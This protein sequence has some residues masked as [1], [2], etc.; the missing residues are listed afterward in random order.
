MRYPT[1]VGS[2][3]RHDF[4]FSYRRTTVD[5]NTICRK[6]GGLKITIDGRALIGARAK[7]HGAAAVAS[8]AVVTR[9]FVSFVIIVVFKRAHGPSVIRVD[10]G[11]RLWT[12]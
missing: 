10:K 4:N 9:S 6:I 5:V 8:C 11:R 1:A 7:N 12:V 2:G 3:G